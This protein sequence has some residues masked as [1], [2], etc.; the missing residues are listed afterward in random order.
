MK[1]DEVRAAKIYLDGYFKALDGRKN[2]Y[3]ADTVANNYLTRAHL[4]KVENV[5]VITGSKKVWAIEDAIRAEIRKNLMSIELSHEKVL[6]K[7][8]GNADGKAGKVSK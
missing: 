7:I 5:R 2:R 1:N 4:A 3:Q 8:R 6:V